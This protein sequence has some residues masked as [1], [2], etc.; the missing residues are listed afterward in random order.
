MT[1]SK[2]E[3]Q[4]Q[5]N[6]T[7]FDAVSVLAFLTEAQRDNSQQRGRYRI[8]SVRSKASDALDQAKRTVSGLQDLLESLD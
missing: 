6:E 7:T 8:D 4:R 5:I 2:T 3:V 1:V